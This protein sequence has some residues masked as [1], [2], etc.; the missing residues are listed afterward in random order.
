MVITIDGPAGSGKSTASR[1]LAVSL[2]VAYLDTGATYRGVAYHAL[3]LGADLEDEEAL[4]ELARNIDLQLVPADD[5]VR[6]LI[7]GQDVST[8]IRTRQITSLTRYTAGSA[9]VRSVL[10]ELQ[11]KIGRELGSFVTEGR[12]QG[13]VVFPDADVKF[14]LDASPEI[15]AR[16][17]TDELQAA[18]T[19]ADYDQILQSII[20]R[21]RR[22]IA[23]KIGPLVKPD[24]AVV[25]DTSDMDINQVTEAMARVVGERT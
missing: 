11:R 16:R 2:G 25:I 20:D 9:L 22:D 13:S 14:Y 17:R 18:G 15:R 8:A 4:A 24:Q 12:D 21:D 19:N 23:R 6:V 10:V 7:S 1:K 3:E 5:G